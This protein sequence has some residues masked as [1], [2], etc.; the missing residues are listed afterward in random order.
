MDVYESSKSQ[1]QYV[2]TQ[3]MPFGGTR[4]SRIVPG[5]G[6]IASCEFTLTLLV[7]YL[8][9]SVAIERRTVR[10]FNTTLQNQAKSTPSEPSTWIFWQPVTLQTIV[11]DNLCLMFVFGLCQQGK[12][13]VM[14]NIL[15]L[16]VFFSS[17]WYLRYVFL[18]ELINIPTYPWNHLK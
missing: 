10:G 14:H 7:L 8:V 15:I 12:N 11:L 17:S 9:F 3:W 13:Q 18:I 1:M 16:S 2:T 6:W 4:V 5:H